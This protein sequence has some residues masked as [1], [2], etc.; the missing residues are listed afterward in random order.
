VN[1]TGL[2]PPEMDLGAA[3]NADQAADALLHLAFNW[4]K[5]LPARDSVRRK[6]A[7]TLQIV[8]GFEGVLAQGNNAIQ[9]TWVVENASAEGYGIIVPE[10]RGEW[11]QVGVLIGLLPEGEGAS[12]G[13]GVVRRV[14][15]DARGQRRV[16]VQVISRILAPGTMCTKRADGERGAPHNVVLLGANPSPS[17]YLQALLRPE[18]FTLRGALEATRLSDGKSFELM[19]SG[20]VES[21]PD[22]DR[23]RFKVVAREA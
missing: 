16:G 12:W 19:P 20:L 6:V 18:S 9:E 14:E 4:E 7:T 17:G 2:L 13:A 3:D 5:E 10:R 11:L 15:S 23:V 8:Q 1:E 21:G 22:F